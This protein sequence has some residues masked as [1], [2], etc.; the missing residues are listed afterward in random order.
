MNLVNV[1]INAKT[2][3][4]DRGWDTIYWAIDLHGTVSPPTYSNRDLTINYYPYAKEALQALSANPENKLILFTSSYLDDCKQIV[5][6]FKLDNII[7]DYV[8]ENPEVANT[9][10]GDYT[11]KLYY[12]ILLDDKAGFDPETD[13][14]KIYEKIS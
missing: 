9:T 14:R 6:R 1:I 8:N 5:E 11:K 7:F 2:L 4:R 3:S 10:Y 12:N 13:W